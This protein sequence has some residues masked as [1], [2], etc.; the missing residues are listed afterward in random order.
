MRHGL[1][2]RTDSIVPLILSKNDEYFLPYVLKAIKG[3][4]SRYI[5]YDVGS[6]DSTRDVIEQ[7]IMV[8]ETDADITYRP[9]PHCE[10]I[11]QGTFRNAMISEAR[12]DFYLLVDCDEVWLQKSLTKLIEEMPKMIEAYEKEGKLYGIVRRLEVS[13]KLDAIHGMNERVPHHRVY[14][15]TAT[16]IGTHPGEQAKITQ[17]SRN[18]Y[19]FLD[20]V[21]LLHFHQPDR[22]SLDE[23]VPGRMGRRF[24]ATYARGEVTPIDLLE[25]LPLLR[26]PVGNFPT[27][28]L[29]KQKQ[30]EYYEKMQQLRRC[31]DPI[32]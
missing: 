27:N 12:A 28:P 20:D 7:F 21:K 5:F 8:E 32:R 22:S 17:K 3:W 11:V 18:E 13:R 6:Q 15:R 24:K 14:H 29:L 31:D 26:T 25:V 30:N 19:N 10:P 23:Q 16:W 4:F 9:L 1:M 2:K